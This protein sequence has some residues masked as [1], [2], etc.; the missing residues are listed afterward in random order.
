MEQRKSY[1]PK[2]V[3]EIC[4]AYRSLCGGFD[5]P[6][7][8]ETINKYEKVIPKNIRVII[9]NLNDLEETAN[10]KSLDQAFDSV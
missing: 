4:L 2:Q 5:G 10:E 7:H 1:L 8:A 9:D 3:A 6:V